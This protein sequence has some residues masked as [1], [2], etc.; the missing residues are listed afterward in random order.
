MG[1]YAVG[2]VCGLVHDREMVR[3]SR[4]C[5]SDR[6]VYLSYRELLKLIHSA[7]CA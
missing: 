3:V 4:G 1:I 5:E 2:S 7:L 6:S